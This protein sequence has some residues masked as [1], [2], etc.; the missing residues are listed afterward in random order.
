MEFESPRITIVFPYPL[1]GHFLRSRRRWQRALL[2]VA[3]AA[4]GSHQWQ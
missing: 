2:A 4:W 1:R 3:A